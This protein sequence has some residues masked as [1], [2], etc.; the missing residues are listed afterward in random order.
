MLGM[1]RPETSGT[2]MNTAI[3]YTNFKDCGKAEELYQRG[4][5]EGY[6]AQLGRDNE[7]TKNCA[8]NSAGCFAIAGKNLKLRKILDD[9][10]HILMKQ[11]AFNEYL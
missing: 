1:N 5:L 11:P 8:M 2:M 7:T 3:V 9:Y 6:E 4:A 10:P